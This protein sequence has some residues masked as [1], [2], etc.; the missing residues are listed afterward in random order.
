MD[1]HCV[2][3]VSTGSGIDG[4][5]IGKGLHGYLLVGCLYCGQFFVARCNNSVF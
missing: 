3:T 5:P 2:V 1:V 4:V